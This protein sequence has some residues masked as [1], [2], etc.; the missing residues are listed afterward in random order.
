MAYLPTLFK[1]SQL[2]CY[3]IV[4]IGRRYLSGEVKKCRNQWVN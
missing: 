1:D 4:T 3:W 2:I